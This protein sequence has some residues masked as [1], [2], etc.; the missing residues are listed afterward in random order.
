MTDEDNLL[1]KLK[2]AA[3]EL[4]QTRRQLQEARERHREPIA[5]VG[6]ACRYP[7]GVDS[8]E[9]LWRL[10]DRGGDAISDFPED[11]GWDTDALFDPDPDRP[12]KSATRKGGFRYDAPDFD[13]DFFGISPREALAMDPQQRLL[14]ETSWEAVERAGIDVTTLKGSRTGVYAGVMYHDYAAGLPSV[15]AEIEGYYGTGTA[16]GVISGRVPYTFGL[17]GPAITVDTACSSSLVALHLAVQALRRDECSL[18]LAGGVAVMSSPVMFAEFSRQGGLSVDGRCKAFGAGADGTGWSEGVGVLVLE[19]LS[20]AVRNGHRVLA[21]V[22]GSAV[23]QD[24]ASNGLTAPSGPAQESVIR[25]ALADAGL[26]A[27]EVDAVE[28]HG[29]GTRLGDPIEARAL[30]AT[31][32]RSRSAEQPLW[33]GSL[34]SNLGHAQAAAGVA[35]VIKMV[36]AMRHGALPRTLHAEEPTPLVDWTTGA[37]ELLREAQPWPQSPDR[38]RRAGVSSFGISGTNAHLILEEA[39]EEPEPSEPESDPLPA[40]G[41]VPWVVSAR[42]EPALRAQARR[43]RKHLIEHEELDTRTIGRGLAT[44]RAR[45]DHRAVLVGADRDTLLTGLDALAE[46]EG[47]A[48][49]IRGTA[50]GP[51]RTAVM[52]TGQGSQRVGMGRELYAQ[53]PVFAMALDEIVALFDNELNRPLRAVMFG[54]MATDE[55]ALDQTEFAQP[56]IFALEVALFRLVSSWGV[57][58]DYLIGHSIGEIT[59]AHIA[60]VLSLHDA[61]RLVAARG[62]L[63]QALPT[64]GAMAALEG[65]EEEVQAALDHGDFH[66]RLEIAAVNSTSSTVVSGDTD[67]VEQFV[68]DWKKD[69]RRAKRLAVSHAFH[70]S[71]MD[72]MLEDFHAIARTL[73][74]HSP[75]LPLI[76]NVTGALAGPREVCSAEYWVDHVRRPV[77]FLDGVQ[78]LEAEGVSAFLELGPDGVLSALGPD[79]AA[80]EQDRVPLFAPGLRGA[81]TPEPRALLEAL[82]RVHVHGTGVDWPAV[83]GAGPVARDLPTY[84]FQRER[85]WLDVPARAGDATGLGLTPAGHPLLGAK[86]SLPDHRGVLWTGRLSLAEQ[87]WLADHAVF[88]SVVVPGAVLVELALQAGGRLEELTLQQPL[89]LGESTGVRLQVTVAGADEDGRR[90]VTVHSCPDGRGDMQAA[91]GDEVWTLHATGTVL[92]TGHDNPSRPALDVWPPRAAAPLPVEDLYDRLADMG[93]AYG[94]LFQ[95]VRAAWRRGEEVFAEVALPEAADGQASAYGIH[96]ALL[97]AALHMSIDPA[98][99]ELRLPF[100]WSDIELSLL[101]AS[102]VRVHLSPSGKDGVSL[103]MADASGAPVLSVGRLVTRPVVREQLRAADGGGVRDALFDVAW[104]PVATK[105]PT[106]VD[107]VR[108]G[109]PEP[110][111]VV[112]WSVADDAGEGVSRVAADA[113]A[114]VQGFIAEERF[115]QSRLVLLTRGAISAA[116]DE[117]VRDMAAASV[118]GLV[119]SAQREHPGRLVLVD[120]EPGLSPEAERAAIRLALS[121]GEPQVAI[122]ADRALAPRLTR[123]TTVPAQAPQAVFGPSGTVLVTGGTGGLGALVAKHLASAYGVRDLLLVSRRGPAADGIPALVAELEQHGTRVRVEACDVADRDALATLLASIPD[124][125]PLTGVVHSA[126]VIDDGI[127]ESL[128]PERLATVLR[129]KAEAALHLHELTAE[130]DLSAFVLFSSFAG[131]VGSAGQAG[132]AAANAALDGLASHRRGR[133]LAAVSLAWG[134]WDTDGGLTGGLTQVDR[135][136]LAALGLSAMSAQEGLALFDTAIASDS[137][138]V[139][140]AALDTAGLRRRE[141]AQ[142]PPLLRTLVGTTGAKRPA[143]TEST[144]LTSRVAGLGEAERRR[145]VLDAVQRQ[146][147]DVLGYGPGRPVAVDTPF[148]NLGFD[149]LMAVELRNQ[150]NQATGLRLPASLVFD[151]PTPKHIAEY[152]TRELAGTVEAQAVT[153]AA[154]VTSDDPIVIVGMACRYPGGVRTPEDL[155]RLVSDGIDAVGPFPDD[156]GWEVGETFDTDAYAAEGGFLYDAADFDADFF[157][158]SPREAL[159]MDPQQR[160]LL[161]TSWEAIERAGIDPKSLKGSST[162]VFSGVMYHDYGSRLPDIPEGLEGFL[163]Y[164][165]AGSVASGRLSYVLGLSGPAVTLDT[166]CSSSLVA[167]HLAADSLRRGESTLALAGGVTVMS[168][169]TAFVEFSRQ[170]GLASDGRCKAF[171]AEA[172]GTGW[173]EG[174]GVLVLERLS[175]AIRNGHHTLAV[176]RGSAINQDG[177]SNGLTAP[178]GPAQEK[179][180][181]QAL[182]NAGLQPQD[183]DAVEAH[184]TGTRLGDPIEAHALLATYGKD[185][186]PHRPLWLGSLKSNLGHTQTAAGVAGVIKT[187]MAMRHGTL[188][189]TL[190]AQEPTPLVDWTTG[191]VELLRQAQ[192]WPPT[193]DRPRRAGV[194][195]F[196]ISGTNAHVILEEPAQPT[197]PADEPPPTGGMVPWILSARTEPALH[198]QARRLHQHL[199]TQPE[200]DMR[201]VGRALATTRSTFEHRAV[202]LTET[203]QTAETTDTL[204]TTLHTLAE[205]E[206]VAGLIRGTAEGPV[207]TAVMFTGQGSQRVGM[208]RELYAQFPVFAEALDEIVALFDNELNRPLRAV[209]FGEMATDEGVLDQTEFA[210]PAIFALEVA[211]FRLVSSWSVRPDYLIGHSIGEITAAHIA[212]VLSLH[213]AVRLV[214]ARG[215]LM[216]ALPADGAMAAL[217]GSEEE[218]QTALDHGDFHGRLE[219]AAVN[220]TSSTVVSGDTDA[221]EKFVADWKK[222]GRRAKRLAVSHAFHSPHMD[223]ML[224]DFRTI[225]HTLDYHSPELPLISNLTGALTQPQEVCSAQYW[226]DHVRRP[227]HFLNGVQALEAEGVSVFL[228]LGPDGVLSALGPDC[229]TAEQDTAPV[230]ATALRGADAPEPRA[231]LEALARTHVHGTEVDWPT[232]LGVGPVTRDLPTYAFQRERFWLDVPARTGDATGLGLTPAGHPLLGAK[233]SLPDHRGVLLTGRLSLAEQPWLADHTLYGHVVLPASALVELAF[234]AGDQVALPHLER[235]TSHEPMVLPDGAGAPQPIQVLV[236]HPDAQGRSTVEVFSRPGDAAEDV[237]WTL[238]AS[239]TLTADT[240][241]LAAPAFEG[242]RADAWPPAGTV[243]LPIQE[244][245]GRTAGSALG[246]GPAFDGVRAAWR[247]GEEVFAEVALPEAADGQASAYGIHPALLDAV[248]R[249]A[250]LCTV[251][252]HDPESVLVPAEWS[253]VE[254]HGAGASAVR[255]HLAPSGEDGVSLHVADASGAPVLSVGRLV[256][257]PVVREQLRA[258]SGGAIRD[259]LFDVAWEPVPTVAK[260]PTDWAR[261]GAPE[262]SEVVVWSVADDAGEGVSRLAADVLA[263]V[264]EFIAEERFA[265]SRLVL[266]TR[267]AISAAP[268]EAVA[269]VAASSIWGLVRSA[270]REHPDRLVLVDIEPGLSP[271]AEQAAIRLALGT[272]EPQVAVRAGR[273]LAPRLTRTTTTP[274][275]TPQA[276]FGP[277]GTVLVTGGTGGLGALVAKHLATAHGV[278][279]L[280]LVS[281]RGPAAPSTPALLTELEQHGARVRVEACDVADRDALATLLDSI[282]D[283]RPLTGVVHCAGVIDDGILESLTPERLATVLRPKAEAALHLHELTA[284]L[285]LSAFVLFSSVAG[286]FGAPGRA[287]Y[288]AANAFLDALAQRRRALGLTAVSAAWGLWAEDRGM[289]GQVTGADLA[290]LRRE[291]A[292]PMPAEE[293]LA[294]FDAVLVRDQPFSVPARLDLAELG[295]SDTPPLSVLRGLV[296][297]GRRRLDAVARREDAPANAA[298]DLVRRLAGLPE[299]EQIRTLIGLVRGHAATVLGHADPAAVS[300]DR[301]FLESGFSSVAVVELRNRLSGATGLRFSAATLFDHPTP[302][303]VARHIRSALAEAAGTASGLVPGAGPGGGDPGTADAEFRAALSALPL[304]RLKEVGVLDALLRLTGFDAVP[305]APAPAA[306]AGGPQDSQDPRAAAAAAAAADDAETAAVTAES[307]DA[308]DLES[309]VHLAINT[310][311]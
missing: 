172:D 83:L 113:L 228:E 50:E 195:S 186:T 122:R 311:A 209:M 63:M 296:R 93:Y 220:S 102:A 101:G 75:E 257:R 141:P 49:L 146:V 222:R 99:D 241:A 271:E 143:R 18:A 131:V 266:L 117:A 294:L 19:R 155:W 204:L 302:R 164:G 40:G 290:R 23:N 208:G 227:V 144:G 173:S 176:I 273:A 269:G 66:G 103:H 299:A 251:H 202:L 139:V 7:G 212:G 248:S 211:L 268:D 234:Q 160:L 306:G 107:W 133:G 8:P 11:R 127:L 189:R 100:A 279:D 74:Y 216:Q 286:V 104:E 214:A 260:A 292:V 137:A 198:A 86:V 157:G 305:G 6:M 4:H 188:P 250:A 247:R 112:V 161:E 118:W 249:T 148:K 39:P 213:D 59:A 132:Y 151:H 153:V 72:A 162:G 10:V 130:L 223:A 293:A 29:T 138:L 124:D 254:L 13:A 262:P 88:G 156:R 33:L 145:V 69:R 35:G 79:C 191:A 238:H 46:G 265:R 196:G 181:R 272:G 51:V 295:R 110:S 116:Q 183:I 253:D 239:G 276:A 48:G 14:L 281:R 261:W 158:I 278:R 120:V 291:G 210:Q 215:R 76:S 56:A 310:E 26:G 206:G 30:L 24:G 119:R 194:S 37:V 64:D 285:D 226:V 89:V 78:A 91:P 180:I 267:G 32:G 136:R 60:G 298:D 163:G 284:G 232:V 126:A 55:G 288:S 240:A 52:F 219:I 308:M 109:A 94:P 244:V 121:S 190:H 80:A 237:S 2:W 21:V 184:G 297:P 182:T 289:A 82:A 258:A 217:E 154:S 205:G 108:W 45:L 201:T 187:V 177:A 87:P 135:A 245:H 114:V 3:R 92:A 282:P 150:L 106:S 5:I 221:V 85:F 256:T 70:S 98:S 43:L 255:V 57:R 128:T 71:H 178:N 95:G 309:L 303:A 277:T 62:R 44:T 25:Q 105:V 242:V 65:S 185:R 115:S 28:A 230:F 231:L 149:S 129:P 90:A 174:V 73:D 192:P 171:G 224:E 140:P 283:D 125:R 123:T 17:N 142:V 259:A 159:A 1:S 235:L 218:V 67:A 207:R 179:V 225:A 68:T 58:P 61:V 304:S 22:R 236:S 229:A 134:W 200:W 169:P 96:P 9:D 81:D 20:D 111:E 199:A 165:S 167:L 170:G 287:S 166:A 77:R 243:P 300:P 38:L 233:V 152:V 47:V 307:I 53:F 31:Y 15:P 301:G 175:D 16:A 147:G 97:D 270:Q 274:T 42:S 193:P 168:S 246:L 264:Q 252:H 203:A 34:K 54:E 27:E 280:L 36:M 275:D 12:G 41:L 197:T 263:V 84:A